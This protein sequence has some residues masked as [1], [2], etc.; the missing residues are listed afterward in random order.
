MPDDVVFGILK[1]KQRYLWISTTKGLT[2]RSLK[3]KVLQ[4]TPWP[5]ACSRTNL[6]PMPI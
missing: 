3:Q 4:I 1:D 6:N 5:M 2:L